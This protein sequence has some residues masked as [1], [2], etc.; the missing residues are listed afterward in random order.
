QCRSAAHASP[1]CTQNEGCPQTPASQNFD[2]QSALVVHGLPVVF[3]F[4]LSGVHVF[5]PPSPAAH[6]PPQHSP[7]VVHAALSAT[8]CLFEH[9]PPT[10]DTVQ[11]S[12]FDAHASPGALHA[13]EAAT[14]CF[15]PVSQ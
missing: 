4:G 2:A 11:H 6:L 8:H 10:H 13:F 9:F 1:S 7:S 12:V 14:H 5:A 3:A 15:V